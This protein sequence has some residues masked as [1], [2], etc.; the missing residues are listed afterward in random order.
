MELLLGEKIMSPSRE[1]P[2]MTPGRAA[3]VGLIDRYLSGLLDPFVSLL[4]V[5]KLMY[6]MQEA[7]ERLRLSYIKAPYGPYAENLRQVLTR[8]EGRF[9]SGYADGGDAPDKQ[10]ELVPGAV[11]EASS[12]LEAHP[13]DSGS[14]RS[15]RRSRTGVRDTVRSRT[16]CDR[17]LG[18]DARRND[19]ARRRGRGHLCL[20][21]SQAPF[22]SSSNSTGHDCASGQ[23]MGAVKRRASM[24][25]RQPAHAGRWWC[26]RSAGAMCGI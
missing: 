15:C 4:E 16:A 25:L 18:A 7:G 21:R 26:S 22:F 11:A 3:L 5:H 17:P 19:G 8:V 12:F 14:V 20:E 24:M 2:K 6:F 13:C 10:L 1:V 23:G 9:V